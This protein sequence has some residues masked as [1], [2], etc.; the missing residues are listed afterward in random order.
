MSLVGMAA[1]MA[2]AIRSNSS[3]SSAC[4]EGIGETDDQDCSAS[5]QQAMGTWVL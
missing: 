4:E 1:A 2:I 3:E 5:D